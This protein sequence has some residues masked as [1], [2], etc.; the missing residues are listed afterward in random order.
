MK[1]K[2]GCIF[3]QIVAG[4]AAAARIAEDE[5]TLAFL[6]LFPVAP[7]HTLI[8]TKQHSDNLFEAEPEDVAAVGRHS[9]ALARALKQTFE[10]DGLG[11]FQL[12]GA[13]AGQTVFHYH[14]HLIP[15]N[16]GQPFL[17]HGRR[18]AEREELAATAERLRSVLASLR[19]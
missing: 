10:P 17:L 11:V 1:V 12:N 3:C 8:V 15:R 6:D 19:C 5:R 2:D 16:E 4:T 14:M 7:G 9:V 18:Q 13:A